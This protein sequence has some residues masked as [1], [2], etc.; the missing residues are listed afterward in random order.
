MTDIVK[1]YLK[2]WI[3]KANEDYNVASQLMNMEF[4]PKGAIGFHCQQ[5]VEKYLKALLIFHEEEVP[6]THSI[7]YLLELA[8]KHDSLFSSFDP[9]NLT[10]YGVEVR[11]PGDFLEPSIAELNSFLSLVLDI[12]ELVLK[13]IQ[14]D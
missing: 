13:S 7:E 8:K 2:Q 5:A 12:K 4:P 1:V 3:D 14:V 10:D 11:Y 6:K 9:G